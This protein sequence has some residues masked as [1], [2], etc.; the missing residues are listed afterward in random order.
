MIL[1]FGHDCGK[2][3]LFGAQHQQGQEGFASFPFLTLLDF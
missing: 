3:A 1:S 2:A